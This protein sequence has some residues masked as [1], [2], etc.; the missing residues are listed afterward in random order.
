VKKDLE[1][2]IGQLIQRE[3]EAIARAEESERQLA[4]LAD[5]KHV[6]GGNV[7]VAEILPYVEQDRF[8]SLSEAAG[9]LRLS[10]RTLKRRLNEMRP[11]PFRV[12]NKLLFKKSDLDR[13][14]EAH[15][16]EDVAREMDEAVLIAEEMLGKEDGA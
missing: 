16:L 7:C 14:I 2:R 4:K 5:Q 3:R 6:L 1:K 11:R 15:R 8:M 12:G 9:Y 10:K 13:W